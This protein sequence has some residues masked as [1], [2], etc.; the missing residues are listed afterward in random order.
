MGTSTTL[1]LACHLLICH[2]SVFSGTFSQVN[3]Y[4]IAVLV[5]IYA[6]KVRIGSIRLPGSNDHP[7]VCF[8]NMPKLYERGKPNDCWFCCSFARECLLTKYLLGPQT[9]EMLCPQTV[10]R[11]TEGDLLVTM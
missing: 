1:E 5:S 10:S 9:V 3:A 4:R 7:T 8:M 11:I 6:I 2:C